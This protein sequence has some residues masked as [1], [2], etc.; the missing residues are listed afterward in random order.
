MNIHGRKY[1]PAKLYDCGGRL[2][3]ASGEN[4][5][6]YVYFS[7]WNPIKEEMHRCS[8]RGKINYL[9]TVHERRREGKY[10][11]RTVNEM[12]AQG[13]LIPKA[14]KEKK[15]E[16]LSKISLIEELQEQHKRFVDRS[17]MAEPTMTDETCAVYKSAMNLFIAWLK[18]NNLEYLMPMAFTKQHAYAYSDYMIQEKNYKGVSYNNKKNFLSAYLGELAERE[19]IPINFFEKIKLLPVTPA[20][21]VAFTEKELQEIKEHLIKINKSELLR[22]FYFIEFVLM[23]GKGVTKIQLHDISTDK[24]VILIYGNK[25]K[26]KFRYAPTIPKF[27]RSELKKLKK[28]HPGEYYL[29][30]AGLKPGA[31][32]ITRGY[33][34]RL[35]RKN[36]KIPLG[37]EKN[38]YW[39]KH[40]G[41]TKAVNAGKSERGIQL[42]GGW[43]TQQQFLTYLVQHGLKTNEEFADMK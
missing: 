10:L 41:V 8:K 14:F 11:A 29:F 23:R 40:T 35:W 3:T 31:V 38:M 22:F 25:G 18:K 42:Q 21:I 27:M 5:D 7:V 12:L 2:K 17:K 37:I 19:I 26:T 4:A 9:K 24:W 1:I 30:S 20:L 28:Q 36:V 32:P 15:P 34:T 43:K 13:E 6:W 33:V 16:P 39:G